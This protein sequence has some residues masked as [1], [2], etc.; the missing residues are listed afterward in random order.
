M[1]GKRREMVGRGKKN[2]IHSLSSNLYSLPYY[3]TKQ[4]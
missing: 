2:Q 1:R 4:K 3:T